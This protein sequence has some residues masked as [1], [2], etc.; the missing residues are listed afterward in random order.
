MI[1]EESTP[2]M[3]VIFILSPGSDPTSE[4]MKLADRYGGGGGKFRYLSLGQSQEK[5]R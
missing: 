3:P 4:L 2:T 5:V 1:F